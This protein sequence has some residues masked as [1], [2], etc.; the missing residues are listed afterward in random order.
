[1]FGFGAVFVVCF[2]WVF[3]PFKTVLAN[4]IS[5]CNDH[6]Q[7]TEH[8]L[9][10]TVLPAKCTPLVFHRLFTPDRE[11]SKFVAVAKMQVSS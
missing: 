4:K 11:Q 1:M 7:H 10:T 2:L 6:C 9:P 8:H 3:F 5:H